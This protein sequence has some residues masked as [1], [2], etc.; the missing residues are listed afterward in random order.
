MIIY[1]ATTGIDE[2]AEL[3]NKFGWQDRLI[4]FWYL[5][6]KREGWLR[7]YVTRGSGRYVDEETEKVRKMSVREFFDFLSKEDTNEKG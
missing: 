7:D 6:D 4:S 3:L 2:Q 5:K 1:L